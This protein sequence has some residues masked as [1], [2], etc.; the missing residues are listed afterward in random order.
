MTIID[1]SQLIEPH[2]LWESYPYV[3]QTYHLGDEFQE[4]GLKWFGSGFSYLSAPGW[5]V[6]GGKRLDDYPITAFAGVAPVVDVSGMDR[7][8]GATLASKL[9]GLP[10]RDL[11]ILKTCHADAQPSRRVEYWKTAPALAA[12]CAAV[13]AQAGFVHVAVDLSCEDIPGHRP[14]GDGG[15]ENPNTAFRT[16]LHAAGLLLT[17][18]CENFGSVEQ[19]EVFFAS[20]PHSIPQGTTSPSRPVALT[21]W[22]SDTPRILDV[23][24]PIFNHWRWKLDVYQG[25]SFDA[26]D[27]TE[28]IHFIF[29]GHGFTHCDAPCH[30]RKGAS[31]IQ[32]LPN[33]GLD[34]FIHDASVIDFSDLTLPFPITRDLIMERAANTYRPGDLMILRSDLTNKLGY[35]SREWHLK[36]PNLEQEAAAWI[37]EQKPAGVCLDF[38]Q[39]YIA[40]EM[41]TRHVRN[42]EF[43]AH[44]AIF[45]ADLPFIEDLKD[46]G[47]LTTDHPFLM[48]IPLKMN[49]VDGAPMRVVAIEW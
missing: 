33:W 29:G 3:S 34:L 35:E 4:F 36:A 26:G 37:A 30:M 43:V 39:D 31:T 20:L 41:P 12:D 21:S 6:K 5:R 44:H 45:S 32:E 49:C 27:D 47:E 18:N 42:E 11:L 17:E 16:A 40:R 46:L 13:I 38:P 22:P 8:D 28:E 9:E 25:S 23:S 2:W 48:A 7:I 1:C 14:E 24:T 19:D 15:Y 10:R